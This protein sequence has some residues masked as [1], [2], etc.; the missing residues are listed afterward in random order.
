ML[1]PAQ[2]A[3]VQQIEGPVLVIAG[4][5]TGKTHI[6]STRVG[7]ILLETD[8]QAH[9]ILCLTFTD[10]GVHAMR[11][12][13]LQLIGPEAHRV[14]IFTFHSFCNTVIQ[15]NLEL[16]G[17]QGLEP[18]NDLERVEVVRQLIDELPVGHLLKRGASDAYQ[19]EKHLHDLFRRMKAEHWTIPFVKERIQTYINDLPNRQE[20]IY[21]VS[22][23]EFKKG[24][25]KQAKYDRALLQ[26]KRLEAGVELF[27][28]Y[29][30]ILKERQ[31]YDYEDMILWVLKAFK[32]NENLLRNYQE[33][34]LYFLLDEFQ[35]TNGA[36]N[37]I[38]QALIGYWENPNI[39]IVG[40]DDQS[41]FEFQ[42][43]RLQNLLEYYEA[44]KDFLKLVVLEENYR[45]K[46]PVLDA[47]FALIAQNDKRI[48]RE[49]DVITDKRLLAKN[50]TV[51]S[52]ETLPEVH[53]YPNHWQ[54]LTGLMQQIETLHAN[55][56][57]YEEIAV[58]YAR[59]K[60][61]PSLIDCLEKKGIPY[62]VKRRVNVL[63]IPLIVQFRWL[64]EYLQLETYQPYQGEA[65]LFKL[66]HSTFLRLDEGAIAK[67]S[68][69]LAGM[70]FDSRP[71][72]RD[73]L[74]DESFLVKVLD[75][76]QGLLQFGHLL[77]EAR[78][79]M[80]KMALPRLIEWL[81]NKM[82]LLD[83]A[84]KQADKGWWINCLHSLMDFV[85]REAMRQPRLM[86]G[87]LLE[88]FRKMDA[89]RIPLELQ[90]AAQSE[91]G[92]QLLTAHGAKG[93]E[94][95]HVF[96][97]DCIKDNWEPQTRGSNYRFSFP[98]TLTLSGEE[99]PMEARRRLF[100]VAMTRAKKGLVLSYAR[101]DERGKERTRAIFIDELLA[102]D[103]RVL[104]L[105]KQVTEAELMDL[106]LA[107]LTHKKEEIQIRLPK[108]QVSKILESFR[109]SVSTF[110]QYLRCPLSFYYEQVL[111]VPTVFSE[112]ATYGTAIH[113]ALQSYFEKVF[114]MPRAGFPPS[115]I[116]VRLFERELERMSGF[117]SRD[118]YHYR[119]QLG[120]QHL[121]AYLQQRQSVWHKKGKLELEVKHVEI[122]GV[123]IK[124]VIDK[125]ELLKGDQARIFDY[126]TGSLN[127]SKLRR[128]T[129]AR[130]YGGTYWRQLVFYK[131]LLEGM[132][133]R[134]YQVVEAGV[135][136]VQPDTNGEFP[137]RTIGID[138]NQVQ[139]MKIWMKEVYE[140]IQKHE[141]YKGCGEEN[142]DWCQFEKLKRKV[143]SFSDLTI[144]ELDD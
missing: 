42:G 63:D 111:K 58:I 18:L 113:N 21:Q 16:F 110:N 71:A 130:P 54:A 127:E 51:Q 79:L 107:L 143:G 3:A 108:D 124:G 32:N 122:E 136:Y 139:Q 41:I 140:E 121:P 23:R 76:Y 82:G 39:F 96:L 137:F 66:L 83:Y 13:L 2:A 60:Q 53:E 100:Y 75:D 77:Q 6:L 98:D 7:R 68:L 133:T 50:E 85:K 86:L 116:L 90:Q 43:A 92:V 65:K 9:N 19:Y 105:Q 101:Q 120:R 64:L 45:S 26:M 59:H 74:I 131:I 141:F 61:A 14:N 15:E 87:Q 4:P 1:N 112:A 52:L 62:T 97:L 35:D 91:L 115:E 33:R 5:G 123:P 28:R 132:G 12:R 118:A 8:A 38:L 142:C 125:V 117:L 56:T 135:D 10:A 94:F 55:G 46:Q 89:N 70:S 129:P 27:E 134:N 72:W 22:R 103:N 48:V 57:A 49:L 109:L 128:P 78:N 25:L 106:Q 102:E 34:Y 99:D 20:F 36:Q 47:A 67:V 81:I 11:E 119:L 104:H 69:H 114:A 17:R 44:Y 88:V 95:E 84:L 24:D 80:G 30:A 31:R 73:L 29:E 40:D 144:E 126:K 93:L 138:Q 37:A